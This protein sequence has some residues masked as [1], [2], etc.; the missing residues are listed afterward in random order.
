MKKSE[1]ERAVLC[2][3]LGPYLYDL[4]K[5]E[6]RSQEKF[7]ELLDLSIRSYAND[8]RGKSLCSTTTILR[9]L[10]R[11][12]DPK[13]VIRRCVELLDASRASDSDS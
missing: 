1:R 5:S 10:D 9:V 11:I 6:S 3:F 4:R 8:E 7:A 12:D 2:P 13:P